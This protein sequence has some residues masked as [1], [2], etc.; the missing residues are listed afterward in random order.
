MA[1]TTVSSFETGHEDMIHDCKV[2]YYG[3]R[4]ATCSSDCSVRIFSELEEQSRQLAE[5]KGH[6]GPVWSCDWAHP[7]FGGLLATVSYDRK[8]IIWR[9]MGNGSQWEI[10]YTYDKHESSVNCVEFA[11]HEAG[12]MVA[13]GSADGNVSI[14]G[15]SD[16]T[17]WDEHKFQ[18]HSSGVNCISW[19]PYTAGESLKFITGGCDSSVKIWSQGSGAGDA[20]S[21]EPLASYEDWVRDAAWAPDTGLPYTMVAVGGQDKKVHIY[22]KDHNRTEWK[23]TSFSVDA[24]VWK[25]SWSLTGNLLA[26]SSGDNRVRLYKETADGEWQCISQTEN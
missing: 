8:L 6:S 15:S 9:D 10:L 5:L 19:S 25:L 18:A 3:K 13:C 7:K 24:V 23:S 22:K 12:L 4:M 26:V 16:L 11:P 21:P 2:D 20:W 1:A 17:S 14:I